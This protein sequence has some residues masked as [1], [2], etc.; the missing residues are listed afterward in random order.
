MRFP[1][2]VNRFPIQTN[3][4]GVRLDLRLNVYPEGNGYLVSSESSELNQPVNNVEEAI[5]AF[6]ELWERAVRSAPER[7]DSTPQ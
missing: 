3:R 4:T 1:E 5:N 2:W 6:R 7:P